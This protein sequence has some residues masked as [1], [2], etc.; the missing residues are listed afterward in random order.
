MTIYGVAI[1]AI[2]A[3]FGVALG[4]ILGQ[5]LHVKANV[6]GVGFAMIFLVTAR[7]WLERRGALT[8]GIKLGVEFWATM[9]IPVVVAMAADQNVLSAVK[10]G[11]MVLV[12]GAASVVSCG[13]VVAIINRLDKGNRD[14]TWESPPDVFIDGAAITGPSGPLPGDLPSGKPP[15][16][17]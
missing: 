2:A 7:V 12:A 8:P 10:S 4:D 13:L 6:G 17:P 5:L 15:G 16:T 9:Y 11:P 1:M 14:D 3:L